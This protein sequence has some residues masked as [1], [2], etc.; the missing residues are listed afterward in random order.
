MW[1]PQRANCGLIRRDLCSLRIFDPLW[2]ISY[3]LITVVSA[4]APRSLE[5]R[6]NRVLGLVSSH[7]TRLLLLTVSIFVSSLKHSYRFTHLQ[8]S[9]PVFTRSF[10]LFSSCRRV[11]SASFMLAMSK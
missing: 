3:T 11:M 1:L 8:V 2:R 10:K 7:L 5:N 4:G 9:Q 6:A